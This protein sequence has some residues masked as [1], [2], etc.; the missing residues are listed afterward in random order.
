[1][2]GADQSGAK[3]ESCWDLP[4]SLSSVLKNVFHKP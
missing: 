3:G 2:T 4:P 1:M